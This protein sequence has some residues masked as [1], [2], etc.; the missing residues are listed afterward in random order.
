MLEL[1]LEIKSK[2]LEEQKKEYQ[3]ILDISEGKWKETVDGLVKSYGK[4][5][6]EVEKDRQEKERQRQLTE[7]LKVKLA[8]EFKRLVEETEEKH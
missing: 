8:E 1:N 7:S 4:K 2:Q 5:L 3:R 6:E